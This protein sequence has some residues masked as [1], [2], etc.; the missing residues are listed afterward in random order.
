MKKVLIVVSVISFIEW[1]N[2]ENIEYLKND[3]GCDVHIAVNADYM[4]DTDEER[5]KCYLKH[6][7]EIG[8][9]I[10][11]IHFA[12]SPFSASNM[13]AYKKLKYII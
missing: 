13:D 12:R 1:F 3:L 2:K 7:K 4:E 6:L 9:K 5:T 11:N 8:V 10:H